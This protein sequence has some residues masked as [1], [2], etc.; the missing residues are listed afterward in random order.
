MLFLGCVLAGLASLALAGATLSGVNL[1][2]TGASRRA[3]RPWI[4]V[5]IESPLAQALSAAFFL[6]VGIALIWIAMKQIRSDR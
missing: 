4:V 6:S 3:P 1:V 2:M 5:P